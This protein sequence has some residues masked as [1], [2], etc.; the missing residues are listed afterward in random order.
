VA[1][2]CVRSASRG[3]AYR[4]TIDLRTVGMRED[5]LGADAWSGCEPRGRR[6]RRTPWSS[7]GTA[8]A[9]PWRATTR[10]SAVTS[11]CASAARTA[12]T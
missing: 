11:S 7:A 3:R 5:A 2:V 6:A 12:G 9:C 8:A 1:R 10:G 4:G